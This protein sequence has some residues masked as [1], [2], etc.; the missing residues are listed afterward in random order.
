MAIQ[1][2]TGEFDHPGR[3]DSNGVSMNNL[4]SIAGLVAM[5]ALLVFLVSLPIVFFSKRSTW[6]SATKYSLGV[7]VAYAFILIV[8][9]VLLRS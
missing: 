7:G 2:N 3:R 5:F 8:L 4:A 6:W 1:P 9:D